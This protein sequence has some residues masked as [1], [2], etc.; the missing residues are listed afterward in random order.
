MRKGS[1]LSR[2]YGAPHWPTEPHGCVGLLV[3]SLAQIEVLTKCRLKICV[4]P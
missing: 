4:S 1:S 2:A 3:I